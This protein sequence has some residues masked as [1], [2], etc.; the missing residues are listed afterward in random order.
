VEIDF[1]YIASEVEEPRLLFVQL[2]FP[3]TIGD[4][5]NNGGSRG[6]QAPEKICEEKGL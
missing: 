3:T 2:Q 4:E 5:L 6:L 1:C